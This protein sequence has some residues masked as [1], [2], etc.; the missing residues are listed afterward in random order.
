LKFSFKTS[1]TNKLISH[2]PPSPFQDK[3]TKKNTHLLWN[4]LIKSTNSNPNGPKPAS[5]SSLSLSSKINPSLSGRGSAN[6]IKKI[7]T[8]K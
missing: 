1:K 6:P 3:A 8:F 2:Q 7:N 4:F 5:I